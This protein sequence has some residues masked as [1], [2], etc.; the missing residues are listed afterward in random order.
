MNYSAIYVEFQIILNQQRVEW[1]A[2]RTAILNN[3]IHRLRCELEVL[4]GNAVKIWYHTQCAWHFQFVSFADLRSLIELIMSLIL[5]LVFSATKSLMMR[6]L[7][8]FEIRT[9]HF[10]YELVLSTFCR[11]YVCRININLFTFINDFKTL[12]SY[13]LQISFGF[14]NI[15]NDLSLFLKGMPMKKIRYKQNYHKKMEL[16]LPFRSV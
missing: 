12:N 9:F 3:F 5:F 7:T 4:S 6:A 16:Y 10:D 2:I 8:T 13:V 1:Y 14:I 15:H 11:F